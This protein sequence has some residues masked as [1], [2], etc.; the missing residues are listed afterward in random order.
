MAPLNGAE[1]GYVSRVDPDPVLK[2]T[3]GVT[4]FRQRYMLHQLMH[5]CSP[6]SLSLRQ[7]PLFLLSPPP[8]TLPLAAARAERGFRG[9]SAAEAPSRA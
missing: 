8:A 6:F 4:C 5:V 9:W 2:H 7:T 3:W 1:G